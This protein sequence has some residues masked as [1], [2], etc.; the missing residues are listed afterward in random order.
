MRYQEYIKD[1]ADILNQLIKEDIAD[2]IEI[3]SLK[4]NEV[5]LSQGDICKY[6]YFVKKGILRSYFI[7][8]GKE[9]TT[10]F[11]FA[12]DVSTIYNSAVSQIPSE[13]YIHAITPCDVY[14]IRIADFNKLK[15]QLLSLSELENIFI[16]SYVLQLEERLF[17]MQSRS[18]SERYLNLMA[19][20]PQYIMKIP[21]KYIASYLGITLETLSRIRAEVK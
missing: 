1:A 8:N 19:E 16:S 6:Y 2:F 14:K 11:T 4:K 5:I 17:M 20:Q 12:N 7:K 21:L 3:V 13:E 18:A 10:N 9:I 15:K